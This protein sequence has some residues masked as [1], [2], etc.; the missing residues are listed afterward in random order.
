MK[1]P[2]LIKSLKKREREHK[3]ISCQCK[4]RINVADNPSENENSYRL[5]VLWV[6]DV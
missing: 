4:E 5:K 2:T 3:V 6:T 1:R